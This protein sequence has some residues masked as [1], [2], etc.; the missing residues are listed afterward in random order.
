MFEYLKLEFFLIVIL[1]LDRDFGVLFLNLLRCLYKFK[2]FFFN[3]NI[4]FIF[5]FF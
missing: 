2:I 3:K 1:Y 4:G 5:R